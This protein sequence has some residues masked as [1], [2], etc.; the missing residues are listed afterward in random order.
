MPSIFV[1]EY[2]PREQGL[3]LVAVLILRFHYLGEVGEYR[4]REQ[5]LRHQGVHCDIFLFCHN[6]GEYRPREQGLRQRAARSV[7]RCFWI[8]GEYRPREQGL[9][10]VNALMTRFF[11]ISSVSIVQENKD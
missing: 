2:R 3:R 4:P 8:V 9:R 7:L 1:G 5:G 11:P 10:H 6:V